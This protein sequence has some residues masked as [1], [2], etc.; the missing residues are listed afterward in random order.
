MLK[1]PSVGRGRESVPVPFFNGQLSACQVNLQ[2]NQ[3]LPVPQRRPNTRNQSPTNLTPFFGMMQPI[4]DGLLP[5]GSEPR[6]RSD[7]FNGL[8]GGR[9]LLHDSEALR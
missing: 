8:P 2:F 5:T 1:N 4:A 9:W 7:F 6:G 3:K